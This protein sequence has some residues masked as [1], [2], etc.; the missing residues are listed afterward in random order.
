MDWKSGALGLI[1]VAMW[2]SAFSSAR[3]VVADAPPFLALS[4]RFALAGGITILIGWAVGQ[5][6]RLS[7][8]QWRAV[9]VFGLCQNALY[10]GLNFLAMQTVEASV[11]VIVAAMLP[12]MVA[13]LGLVFLRERLSPVATL[14]LFAGVAGVLLIMSGR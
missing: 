5:S 2:S 8:A 4:L 10:L 12:L 11:A 13:A 1:F 6:L 7:A 9:L 3:M 14:G